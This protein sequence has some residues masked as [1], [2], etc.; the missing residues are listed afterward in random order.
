[1][2]G[3]KLVGDHY[4]R[5]MALSFQ[6]LSQQGLCRLGVAVALHQNVENKAVLIDGAPEPE[7]LASNR[8]GNLV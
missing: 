2:G 4:T 5:R 1:M 8:D 3:L 7:F 6:T